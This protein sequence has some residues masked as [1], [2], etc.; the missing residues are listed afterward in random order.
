MIDARAFWPLVAAR[1]HATPDGLCAV[2]ECGAQLTFGELRARAARVAA[3]LAARSVGSDVRVSWQLPTWIESLVLVAALAR[4]GAVQNPLLPIYREREIGFI[5]RQVRPKLLVVPREF[6]GFDHASLAQRVLA[7]IAREGGAP[8]ELLVCDRALPEADPAA[9]PAF[10]PARGEPVRWIFYTSGTTADPKGALHSD[11]TLAA[12]SRGVAER[13]EFG[14]ADRY[15]IVFPFTH[16]GGIGMLVVQLFTGA[17]A[18]LVEQYDDEKTPPLLGAHGVTLAAGGTPL[19]M[20][21]LRYQRR[22]PGARVFPLL[23]AAIGGA[24][25]KPPLLHREVKAELGGAG[26]L[27]VYGLTE[28]PF[29]ALSSPRDSDSALAHSEGRAAG[30][31]ELRIAGG[32][33]RVCAPDAEGE[34]RVRGPQICRGYLDAKLDADAFDADGFFRTGD[35]GSLDA[36]GFLRVTGRLKEIIIRNGENIS[37]KEIEDLLYA[38][39]QIADAAVIGL[40]DPRTGERCCAVVVPASGAA[41]DLAEIVRHCA[42]A[43]LAR[44]KFPEQLELVDALPRNASGKVQKHELRRSL[45][46]MTT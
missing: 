44:Q 35:L 11:E 25:P 30:G 45:E 4:L 1:A 3:A 15:P 12:G 20:R 21:Y 13:F 18:I 26:V 29:A 16:I 8:C 33:G 38:H 34:I 31:A 2:D 27:S 42:A 28:A 46:A 22:H 24:A 14:P 41:L 36:H 6:R 40:P 39:P 7:G 10:A 23:R 32:D 43:G 5:A 17:G 19:V 9:L 37:A